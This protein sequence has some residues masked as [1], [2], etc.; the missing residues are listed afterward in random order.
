MLFFKFDLYYRLGCIIIST[1]FFASLGLLIFAS[2]LPNVHVSQFDF[3]RADAR[4]FFFFFFF[5]RLFAYERIRV[6]RDEPKIPAGSRI[7]CCF[8]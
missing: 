3:A 7:G 8:N 4:V 2:I 5:F 6:K 1:I